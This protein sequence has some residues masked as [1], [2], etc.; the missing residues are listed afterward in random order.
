MSEQHVA[1]TWLQ[2]ATEADSKDD[3]E[4]VCSEIFADVIG[5]V[6]ENAAGTEGKLAVM[7]CTIHYALMWACANAD[8]LRVPTGTRYFEILALYL[9]QVGSCT[10]P[11]YLCACIINK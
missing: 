1:K 11:F 10:S 6:D 2:Q 5:A 7:L 4:T 3:R 9:D 8:E